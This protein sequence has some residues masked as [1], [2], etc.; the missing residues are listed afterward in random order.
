MLKKAL[1]LT[2]ALAIGASAPAFAAGIGA[3]TPSVTAKSS[4]VLV[5]KKNSQVAAADTKAK[6]KKKKKK[7]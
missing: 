1:I 7:A 6:K 3:A 5:A 4:T 2:T